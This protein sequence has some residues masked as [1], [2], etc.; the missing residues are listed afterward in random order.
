MDK[1]SPKEAKRI[2]NRLMKGAGT[3]A[4]DI[5]FEDGYTVTYEAA[6]AGKAKYQAFLDS[7]R[8]YDF[9]DFLT[10]IESVKSYGEFDVSQVFEDPERFERVCGYRGTAF[11]Y[12]GQLVTVRGEPGI[13]VGGNAGANFNVRFA[14]GTRNCHPTYEMVYYGS[15]GTVVADYEAKG[16]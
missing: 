8:G 14:D 10:F 16:V 2:R 4:Y 15:D 11:A 13:L 1:L 12:Q 5:T 9:I 7:E 6:T 3:R